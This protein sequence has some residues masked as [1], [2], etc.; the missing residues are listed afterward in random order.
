DAEV[1]A[2]FTKVID[3]SAGIENFAIR[4]GDPQARLRGSEVVVFLKV[5]PNLAP[6]ALEQTLN[7]LSIGWAKS[8]AIASRVDSISLKLV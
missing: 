6:N 5:A 2:E 7:S 3:Q 8:E 1:R 4:D